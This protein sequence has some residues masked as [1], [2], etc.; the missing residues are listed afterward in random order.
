MS[1]S[2]NYYMKRYNYEQ[3]RCFVCG[4]KFADTDRKGSNSYYLQK[5]HRT[6]YQDS[7]ERANKRRKW[8]YP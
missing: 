3:T 5:H 2:G 6:H 8:T 4:L 7:I 1:D